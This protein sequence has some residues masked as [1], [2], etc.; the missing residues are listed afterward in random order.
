MTS[1]IA[2]DGLEYSSTPKAE[3]IYKKDL[4]ITSKTSDKDTLQRN[5]KLNEFIYGK[6][7]RSIL[8]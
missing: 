3:D 8:I 7:I 1:N 2:K 5:D 4:H 6:L